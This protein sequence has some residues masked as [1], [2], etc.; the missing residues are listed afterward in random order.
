[1]A[2]RHRLKYMKYIKI[3]LLFFYFS[4]TSYRICRFCC[5]CSFFVL[6]YIGSS[7]VLVKLVSINQ[8]SNP[9]KKQ[10]Q[11]IA[12]VTS[13]KKFSAK[14]HS[15]HTPGMYIIF[16]LFQYSVFKSSRS[17][18]HDVKIRKPMRTVAGFFVSPKRA[19]TYSYRVVHTN[20]TRCFINQRLC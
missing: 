13:N 19:H 7:R 11:L 6:L 18:P 9:W 16:F 15:F 17:T 10:Q 4:F 5:C 3:P 1:M 20:D 2:D 14:I 8:T 12:I